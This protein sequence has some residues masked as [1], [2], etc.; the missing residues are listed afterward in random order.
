MLVIALLLVGCAS[1]AVVVG[2]VR[3][4]LDVSQVKIYLHPPKKYEE[5]AI[6]EA[7]SKMAIAIGAQAKTNLVID[8]LKQEAAK[9]GANGLLLS[10]V[11]DRYAGSTGRVYG[12][13]NRAGGQTYSQANWDDDAVY[14]KAGNGMAI[15]VEEE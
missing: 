4:P 7:N 11:G 3:P 6:V 13:A 12:N 10:N 2:K 9:I 14:M 1:S 15:F 5:V 8:R